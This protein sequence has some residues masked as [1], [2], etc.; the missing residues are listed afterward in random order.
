[1]AH[2]LLLLLLAANQHQLMDLIKRE[3]WLISKQNERPSF[4]SQKF[5][6]YRNEYALS[7]SYDCLY[8]L[9]L[10]VNQMRE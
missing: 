9:D 10:L 1:M 2:L 8:L 5:H 7:S 3:N 6:G 4:E